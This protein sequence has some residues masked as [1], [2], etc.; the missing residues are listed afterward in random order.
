VTII[1]PFLFL[2]PS[3]ILEKIVSEKLL[4]HLTENDFLYVHQYG[5]L[6]KK[7]QSIAYY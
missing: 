1:T 3:K 6:P 7:T 2:N 5:F 4:Y